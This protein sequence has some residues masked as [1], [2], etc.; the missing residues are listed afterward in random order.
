MQQYIIFEKW[1]ISRHFYWMTKNIWPICLFAVPCLPIKV[2]GTTP[3]CKSGTFPAIAIS[4][5][6]GSL[7]FFLT[8]STI[9]CS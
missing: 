2:Q 4:I 5:G 7:P 1:Q 6:N 9:E 3:P 8:V